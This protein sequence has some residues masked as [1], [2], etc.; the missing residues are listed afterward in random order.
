MRTK[1]DETQEFLNQFW[2]EVT[3]YIRKLGFK[4]PS[5]EHLV[6]TCIFPGT[7]G[8]LP[9]NCPDLLVSSRD[10]ATIIVVVNECLKVDMIIRHS[11]CF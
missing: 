9:V 6:K 3:T 8:N 11:I 5:L 1:Q 7:K 10:F 4:Q 2:P